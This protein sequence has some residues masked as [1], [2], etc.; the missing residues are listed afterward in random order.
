MVEAHNALLRKLARDEQH[1]PLEIIA[2][3]AIL[4]HLF[5]KAK[6]QIVLVH[7]ARPTIDL[8]LGLA[9]LTEAEEHKTQVQ[10]IR[11][12]LQAMHIVKHY[13][14][15]TISGCA[16]SNIHAGILHTNYTNFPIRHNNNY[17]KD[18]QLNT[19]Y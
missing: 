1:F 7:L 13:H 9:L 18:Q 16:R 12:Q 10:G 19:F 3:Q 15:I 17:P 2:H 14:V 8:K 6:Q 11:A 5:A 4:K